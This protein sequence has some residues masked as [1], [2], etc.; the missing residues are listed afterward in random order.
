MT[1]AELSFYV[2]GVASREREE[3]KRTRTIA[4]A[5][6]QSQAGK[7]KR[8]KPEQ[9][10]KLPEDDKPKQRTRRMTPEEYRKLADK[11]KKLKGKENGG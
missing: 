2:Q 3:W 9:I 8:I 5:V 10:I 1:F 4:W 7:G 6:F 11:F